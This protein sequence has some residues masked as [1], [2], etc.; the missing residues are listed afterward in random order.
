MENFRPEAG[1]A[2]LKADV[3]YA[4]FF[5]MGPWTHGLQ[6]PMQGGTFAMAIDGLGGGM[7]KAPPCDSKALPDDQEPTWAILTLAIRH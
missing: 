4:L 1:P 2:Y 3:K 7:A 5:A 6:K